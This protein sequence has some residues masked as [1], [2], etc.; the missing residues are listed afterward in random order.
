MKEWAVVVRRRLALRRLKET[1]EKKSAALKL[2]MATRVWKE[3]F[4]RTKQLKQLL[5]G[6]LLCRDQAILNEAF[7]HW[8]KEAATRRA[9]KHRDGALLKQ[10]WAMWKMRVREK[11]LERQFEEDMG[12]V[13]EEHYNSWLR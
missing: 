8:R 13:A 9:V 10:G 6:A 11:V 5:E 1:V 3:H 4:Q 7:I 2:Q 12:E